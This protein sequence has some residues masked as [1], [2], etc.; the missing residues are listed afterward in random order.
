M[1]DITQKLSYGMY[2]VTSRDGIAPKGC[3]ANCAAQVTSEP[4]TVA[5][6]INRDNY[7]NKCIKT[8]KRFAV[9]VL[10]IDSDP[11]IIRT[12][13]FKSGKDFDKFAEI[14]YR[15]ADGLPVIPDGCGYFTCD[16]IDVME[17][18]THT[19]FLG[20]IVERSV[21]E[22]REQM[23][24]DYYHKV[25]K[26]SSPKNAPTYVPP[27]KDVAPEKQ[28]KPQKY[29]CTVCGYEHEGELPDDFVCPICGVGADMFEPV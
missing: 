9:S 5:V 18:P 24:Y 21:E 23:T 20:K 4:A 6:S 14:P 26:G 16:V 29:V 13:G 27:Q 12:F 8:T 10:A 11:E 2:V 15:T 22:A 25:I 28:K 3:I 17:T 7:T 19:V 1:A